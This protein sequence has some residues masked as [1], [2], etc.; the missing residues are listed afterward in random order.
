[1]QRERFWHLNGDD[2]LF[3]FSPWSHQN[4]QLSDDAGRTPARRSRGDAAAI[5]AAV[6]AGLVFTGEL[7][8]PIIDLRHYLEP[9]LDMHHSSA[10]FSTR[11]RLQ[12]RGYAD[13]QLIWMTAVPHNPVS[14]ALDTLLQWLREGRRPLSAQDSCFAA[15]GTLLAAGAEVWDG[16]WNGKPA[17]ACMKQYPIYGTPRSVAGEDLRGDLFKCSLISVDDAL[18]RGVYDPI[19]MQPYRSRLQRIFPEGVC[20]YSVPGLGQR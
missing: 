11:L 12:Q 14:Q 10:A 17:G 1:M 8:I 4:M 2:N 18:S 20:D 5:R 19:D 3:A 16:S 15:D 13:N 6:Q 9:A 7:S